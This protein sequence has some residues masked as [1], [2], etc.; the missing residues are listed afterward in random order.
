M[1]LDRFVYWKGELPTKEQLEKITRIS[2]SNQA[3]IQVN[4]LNPKVLFSIVVKF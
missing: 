4:P 1:A 2:I 3:F